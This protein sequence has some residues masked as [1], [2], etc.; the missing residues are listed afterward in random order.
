MSD[1]SKYNIFLEEL[2]S[3]EKQI[4][5]FQQKFEETLEQKLALE[6][7]VKQLEQERD[8]LN[9]KYEELETELN[10]FKSEGFEFPKTGNI[11]PKDREQLKLKIGDLINKIDHHLRT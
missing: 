7:K 3:L 2:S 11:D 4:Y 5:V 1:S 8:V 9:L 10:N 6:K